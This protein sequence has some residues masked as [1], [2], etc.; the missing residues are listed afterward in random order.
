MRK[1]RLSA[2]SHLPDHVLV[3]VEGVNRRMHRELLEAGDPPHPRG[4]F[5]RLLQMIPERGIRITDLAALSGM[6]KQS[7]GEF[8]N[9][10]EEDG[11]VVSEK[12][13]SDRR[14]R[15]VVRTADGERVAREVSARIAAVERA[16]R[17]EAGPERYDTMKAVLYDL[18]M[19][20]FGTRTEP[21]A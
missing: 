21:K 5:M 8:V 13:P 10:M 17:K 12:L 14:V 20:S 1:G 7:L 6:T 3:L 2:A 15:V 11:L 9:A 16:W 18:G 4:G 19:E